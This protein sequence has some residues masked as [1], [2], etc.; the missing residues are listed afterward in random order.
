VIRDRQRIH[1]LR[2]DV[3]HQIRD[4]VHSVQQT[5]V[6]VAVQVREGTRR[7]AVCVAHARSLR[8]LPG[9]RQPAGAFLSQ[10]AGAAFVSLAA[11]LISSG[12]ALKKADPEWPSP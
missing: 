2:F 1:S 5:V 6:R 4:P 12:Y 8:V 9:V 10:P 3:L 11:V 7:W